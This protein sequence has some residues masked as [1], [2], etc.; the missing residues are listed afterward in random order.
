MRRAAQVRIPAGQ[1]G[2]VVAK[3]PTLLGL[4][5]ERNLRPKLEFLRNEVK[6]RRAPVRCLPVAGAVPRGCNRW[7]EG[8][9]Q[10]SLPCGF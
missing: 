1:L 7:V 3:Y 4:S 8:C 6:V 9:D 10:I 2:V 5:V